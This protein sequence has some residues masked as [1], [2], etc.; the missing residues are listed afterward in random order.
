MQC[1]DINTSYIQNNENFENFRILQIFKM[2]IFSLCSCLLRALLVHLLSSSSSSS[3]VVA[4]QW[5]PV[6][7]GLS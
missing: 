7:I 1:T 3:T 2:C 4:V 6:F 5:V